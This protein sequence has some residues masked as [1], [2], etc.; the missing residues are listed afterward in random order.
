MRSDPPAPTP[1]A[2][3]FMATH[4]RRVYEVE[5]WGVS[6]TQVALAVARWDP[7]RTCGGFARG[8]GYRGKGE[9]CDHARSEHEAMGGATE[10]EVPEFSAFG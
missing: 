7:A 9:V 8:L 1:H 3:P 5:R 6:S 10:L 4:G 2:S